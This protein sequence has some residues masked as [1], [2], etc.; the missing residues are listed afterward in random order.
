M[1]G[2][3]RLGWRDPGPHS[4]PP[5]W[6]RAT[7][8]GLVVLSALGAWA[9]LS[10]KDPHPGELEPLDRRGPGIKPWGKV[11]PRLTSMVSAFPTAF[12][13]LM[14]ATLCSSL[15]PSSSLPARRSH[16]ADSASHLGSGERVTACSRRAQQVTN[17]CQL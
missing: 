9:G 11:Q 5:A 13:P 2:R 6:L 10:L 3:G 17:S 16:L 15:R 1:C 14:A 8:A 7:P 12:F 4:A